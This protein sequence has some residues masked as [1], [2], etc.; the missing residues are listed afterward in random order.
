M[1]GETLRQDNMKILT[2]GTSPFYLTRNSK[3]HDT[4]I[5]NI[6]SFID[7]VELSSIFLNHDTEYFSQEMIQD[8]YEGVDCTFYSVGLSGEAL[9]TNMFDITEKESPDVILSIGGF[10]D[11]EHIRA[12]KRIIPDSFKWIVILTS[13]I[14]YNLSS[15]TDTLQEAD[16][17]IC[18]TEQSKNSLESFNIDC[19]LIKY[20]ICE[21]YLS[22]CEPVQK[23]TFC[24]VFMI[25]DKNVQQSN[26]ALVL[27][28]FIKMKDRNFKILLHTNYYESGEYD[29][30]CL[31]SQLDIKKVE[32]PNSFVGIRDGVSDVDM[33]LSYSRAHFIVDLSI[34]PITS[35]CALEGM[36]QGCVPIINK[37]GA[38]FESVCG[39]DCYS[40]FCDLAVENNLFFSDHFEPF[41]MASQDSFINKID[42][43]I[44]M[45]E[46]NFSIYENLSKLAKDVSFVFSDKGFCKN[47]GN[48][49][50]NGNF[51]KK[52]DLKLKLEN[53]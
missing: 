29:L 41:Y 21:S 2:T 53:I 48:L 30:D 28:S 44:S 24:P 43:A 3:I 25:N 34:K 40:S 22:S 1:A 31:I 11:L 32:L 37:A 8:K 39:N 20:G 26:M 35:L 10:S 6:S 27:D 23:S 45:V 47:V 52:K 14:G 5:R 46:D 19:S 4:I 38:L 33:R 9:V 51:N 18:L 42:S 15:F 36:S 17:V 49:I 16:H 13:N 50:I 7:D 12:I